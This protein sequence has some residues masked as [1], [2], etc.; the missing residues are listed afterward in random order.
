MGG[1]VEVKRGEKRA[2][3]GKV[4]LYFVA[5]PPTKDSAII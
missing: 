1:S 3:V 2:R 5:N 4:R